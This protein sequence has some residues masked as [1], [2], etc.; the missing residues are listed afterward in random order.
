MR[1]SA[2][3]FLDRAAVADPVGQPGIGAHHLPGPLLDQAGATP[4]E[5]AAMQRVQAATRLIDYT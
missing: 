2:A 1:L 3:G 4:S 5:T